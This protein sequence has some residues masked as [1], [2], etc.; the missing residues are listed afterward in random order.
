MAEADPALSPLNLY[1]HK[2]RQHQGLGIIPWATAAPAAVAL[3]PMGQPSGQKCPLPTTGAGVAWALACYD[4]S[5][6]PVSV[7][8]KNLDAR[9]E[10]D[11]STARA[12]C[13]SRKALLPLEES[14]DRTWSNLTTGHNCHAPA[15]AYTRE[16]CRRTMR[17]G[18]G[19]YLPQPTNGV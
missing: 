14:E 6:F 10:K 18:S 17:R 7:S 13:S 15:K 3:G 11:A 8:V 12:C 2:A 1:Y 16:L 5:S 4:P 9:R 19:A